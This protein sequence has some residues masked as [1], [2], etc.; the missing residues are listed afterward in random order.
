MA[1]QAIVPSAPRGVSPIVQAFQQGQQRAEQRQQSDQRLALARE[2]LEM[3]S[4]KLEMDKEMHVL[5]MESARLINES[6]EL[7]LR[8]NGWAFDQRIKSANLEYLNGTAT[9][10]QTFREIAAR[11]M[12]GLGKQ[13]KVRETWGKP[14]ADESETN[15][16]GVPDITIVIPQ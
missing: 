4:E 7:Q 10:S 13:V 11:N 12:F 6:R 9:A 1:I 2:G 5:Q 15:T 8:S 16:G 3:Q 14:A